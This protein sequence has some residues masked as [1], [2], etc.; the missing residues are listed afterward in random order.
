M[1]LFRRSRQAKSP[2]F[3]VL[4]LDC[5][6][7][8]LIFEQFNNELPNI[9]ALMR[10]GTWGELES[11][12]PCITI[13]AWASMLT[14]RDPGVLGFYGFRNRVDYSYAKMT[15]VNGESIKPPR[16][17][18]Y[19]GQSGKKSIVMGV[20][21]TYPPK[22]INGHLISGFLT[23]NTESAFTYPA[24]FKHEIL[25]HT[26]NYLF[27]VKNFRTDNKADL[28]QRLID[29]SEIQYKVVKQTLTSK[30]WDFFMHVNMATDRLHHGFWRFHDPKH[31]LYEAANPFENTIRDYYKMIDYQL[32]EIISLLDDDVTV[33]IVSDHGV[34][35]MDGGIC[36]NEW[37]WRNGWLQFK[38]PP[39]NGVLTRFDDLEI[40]WSQTKAW[41]SGGYYGRIF[42]N[43]DGRELQGII[44]QE[45]YQSVRDD[46]AQQLRNIPS[47][48]GEK[49]NTRI[50][51]PED[52]YSEVNNIAPDLIAY[53]GDLHWRSVGSVGHGST[54]TLENDTGPDD[55]NHD[56]HGIFILSEPHHAGAGYVR[57]HQLRDIT[58]TILD[59]M[60]V[61]IP[62]DL[63]GRVIRTKS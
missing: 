26:P 49:L 37:L 6:D 7:P 2:R 23:P 10:R 18:D 28:L 8:Q 24:I 35:R 19:L 20:P 55:A 30:P 14:G 39:A 21:Q 34:K 48:T 54:W 52:V 53:F 47:P 63:Q 42:L 31:R 38:T 45:S 58:S 4:G 13:P 25:K 3:L 33:L 56:T 51:Q 1:S 59:R 36:I 43:V 50:I 27:D 17:W 40:D 62:S 16:I 22:P 12:T 61:A 32:G 11:T 41:G 60:N 15:V 29:F 5:A 46:L 57:G 44:P 9:S